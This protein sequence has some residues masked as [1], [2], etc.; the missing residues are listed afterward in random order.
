MGH[1]P[2]MTTGYTKNNDRGKKFQPSHKIMCGASCARGPSGE[3]L[4]GRDTMLGRKIK[5]CVGTEVL[6]SA[7]CGSVA[8]TLKGYLFTDA[9]A[10][11]FANQFTFV[12]S[13]WG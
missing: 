1:L 4:T 13:L 2:G 8:L 3:N 10:E 11:T 12:P 5:A 7:Q 6:Y 9:T